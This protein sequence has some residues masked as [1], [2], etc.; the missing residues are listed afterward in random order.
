MKPELLLLIIV[1]SV[2]RRLGSGVCAVMRCV[3]QSLGT[4]C[5][6]LLASFPWGTSDSGTFMHLLLLGHILG[7]LVILSLYFMAL[8][9]FP[10]HRTQCDSEPTF[11]PSARAFCTPAFRK[12]TLSVSRVG[13]GH[14]SLEL[15]HDLLS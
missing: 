13:E 14:W 15:F 4:D 2:T 9:R 12:A 1:C 8:T 11:S 10:L 7:E 5:R 6:R 3:C